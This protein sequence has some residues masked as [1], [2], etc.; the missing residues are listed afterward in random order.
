MT[1]KEWGLALDK[2]VIEHLD[3]KL[4]LQQIIM[5]LM[6]KVEH[7]MMMR[8]NPDANREIMNDPRTQAHYAKLQGEIH[9]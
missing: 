1:S 9:G 2:D 4:Y 7:I 6:C 8:N 3:D 5:M